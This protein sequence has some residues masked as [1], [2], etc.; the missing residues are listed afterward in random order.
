MAGEI[1]IH[2]FCISYTEF[3]PLYKQNPPSPGGL[4]TK[5]IGVKFNHTADQ[6]VRVAKGLAGGDKVRTMRMLSHG[7]SGVFFFPDMWNVNMLS[8]KYTGLRSIFASL[9]RLELHGCGIAS[10]TSVLRAGADPQNPSPRDIV[11]GTFA[12]RS[13]G[14][15]LTYLR[16]VASIFNVPTTAAINAQLVSGRDWSFEGDTVTMFPNGKF[17]MDSEGTRDW[18][19]PATN[20]EAERYRSFILNEY[21][22]KRQYQIAIQKLR[23]LI[24]QYPGTSAASWA[25]DHL[26]ADDLEDAIIRPD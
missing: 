18:D 15:G 25:R 13:S 8:Q 16:R 14:V 9:G 6:I 2:L 12:G 11:P 26:T 4:P 3:E 22:T 7:N 5:G 21:V 19:V 23:D 24:K 17:V 1:A 20:R 10:E